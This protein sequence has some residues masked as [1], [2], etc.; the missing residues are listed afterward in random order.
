LCCVRLLPVRMCK[1]YVSNSESWFEIGRFTVL[2]G[3][4]NAGKTTVL[5]YIYLMLATR[6]PRAGEV[7]VRG[8]GD[9]PTEEQ[10]GSTLGALYVELEPDCPFDRKVLT[11]FPDW[12]PVKDGAIRFDPLPP[13]QVCYASADTRNIELWF[14]DIGESYESIVELHHH[15][16]DEQQRSKD[17][18]FPKPLSL[19]WEFPDA[20]SWVTEAIAELTPRRYKRFDTPFEYV[21][22]EEEGVDTFRIRPEVERRVKQLASLATDLLPDFLDGEISARLRMPYFWRD[23]L[24]VEVFYRGSY[25][26][27]LGRGSSRWMG[28]ALQIALRIME[29]N[30]E[31]T[32]LESLDRGELSGHVL[33]L[34]EP[35]AHLH[36]SAVASIVRWCNRMVRNGFNLMAASH[37]EEFLRASGED[38]TFVKLTQEKP[39]SINIRTISTAATSA[40]QELAD[41]V[42]MHPATALS[43]HRAILFVEGPLDEAVLDEY[44]G[45]RLDAAGVTVIP[46]HGTKNLEGLIDGELTARLGIKTGV[47]T[48]NTNVETIW[49]R[50]NKKRS[51]EEVKLVRLIK[52]FEEQGLPPPTLFGVAEDDLLFALPA[53]AIRDYL[54]GPFPGW[55]EL[56]EECRVAEGRGLSESVDWKT[57]ALD[58]YRLPVTTADGVR[59][60]VR[61]LDLAGVALL[62]IRTVVDEV[63][64]WANDSGA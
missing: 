60:I 27:Q 6:P 51:S 38:V 21:E 35:E 7:R 29:T 36:H 57:Y 37:H 20:N 40:L 54:G 31:A 3:K 5:D 44:E 17:G 10:V 14:T 9:D 56:R 2:F 25:L 62:S 23:G 32:S 50:S 46:I 22:N 4:N 13:R 33:F 59:R 15:E 42:G 55:Q 58:H 24:H 61:S 8:T 39:R 16:L 30:T 63:I 49:D 34:D 11:S 52:R 43:L 28:I 47:L 19:G 18:P 1:V 12:E 26:E 48:D 64:G 41:E 45:G 53:E